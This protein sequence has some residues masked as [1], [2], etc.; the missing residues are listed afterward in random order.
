MIHP[1]IHLAATR[2]IH[3]ERVQRAEQYRLA[4]TV[5]GGRHPWPTWSTRPR[6]GGS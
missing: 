6:R 1:D 5:R 3:R 4:R 2:D